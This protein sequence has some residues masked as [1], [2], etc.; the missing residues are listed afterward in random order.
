MQGGGNGQAAADMEVRLTNIENELRTLTGK[1]EQQG[2]EQQQLQKS[3]ADLQA[4]LGQAGTQKSP[5]AAPPAVAAGPETA[6]PPEGFDSELYGSGPVTAGEPVTN[7]QPLHMNNPDAAAPPNAPT[8]GKLGTLEHTS[9]GTVATSSADPSNQYEQAFSLLRQ[10]K[11]DEAEKGFTDFLSQNPDSTLAPNAQYW[12]GETFYARNNFERAARVFAESYQKYP[13]GPKAPDSL[14]KLAL[15]L[16]GMGKK[17]D[18]CLS[19]TQ[20]KHEYATGAGAVIA[21][22]DQE[23]ATLGCH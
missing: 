5:D 16:A 1:V 12:L 6:P 9:Q 7:T 23:S 21:R 19:I 20:L 22:A 17:E 15:S 2:Y 13:K 18:A 4:R 3:L 14:L 11:Y 8:A 10:R